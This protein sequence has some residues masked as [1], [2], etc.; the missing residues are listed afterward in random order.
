MLHY[1]NI[2]SMKRFKKKTIALV[3]ASVIAMTSAF[4]AEG[5]KNT[6]KAL[7]FS[8]MGSS[9]NVKIYTQE[10]FNG[11][12]SINRKMGGEYELILP[13]TESDLTQIPTHSADILSIDIS[14]I[15]Y[16]ETENGYTKIIIKTRPN[17]HLSA[18]TSLYK[19]ESPLGFQLIPNE[20]ED[21]TSDVSAEEEY[22]EDPL[23]ENYDESTE[24]NATSELLKVDNEKTSEQTNLSATGNGYVDE[25]VPP[26]EESPFNKIAAIFGVI[27]VISIVV[28]LFMRAKAQMQELVGDQQ[29]FDVSDEEPQTKTKKINKTVKKLDRTYSKKASMPI[30]QERSS[31]PVTPISADSN[32]N[33]NIEDLDALFNEAKQSQNANST[34]DTEE[35]IA[36]EEF[37]SAYS[38]E[39]EELAQANEQFVEVTPSDEKVVIEELEEA[40]FDE[41]LFEKCI[42]CVNLKF[43]QGDIDKI[44]KLLNSEINDDTLKNIKN[45][46]VSNPI[47]K[48]RSKTEVLEDIVT[49]YAIKQN[50]IFTHEDII[51]LNKLISVEIDNDFITDLKTDPIRQKEIL[52]EFKEHSNIHKVSEVLKLDV[53]KESLPNLS[54]AIEKQGN[55][56]IESNYKPE[57]VYFSKGYDVQTLEM[58]ESMPDLSVEIN[59]RDAYKTRPSDIFQVAESGYNVDTLKTS[60]LPDLQDALLNPE[61]YADPEEEP[62]IVTE[63][64]LLKKIDNVVFKPFDDGSRNFEVINNLE[65]FIEEEIIEERLSISDIQKELRDLGHLEIINEDFFEVSKDSFITE[66]LE[67]IDELSQWINNPNE[68]SIDIGELDTISEQEK[69]EEELQEEALPKLKK[70]ESV[71]NKNRINENAEN[72]LKLIQESEQ[73]TKTT[74]ALDITQKEDKIQET[75]ESVISPETSIQNIDNVHPKDCYLDGEK[76][77]IVTVSKIEKEVGCYLTKK[78]EN[79]V[80]IGY[81][82]G[83][84]VKLREYETLK[85]EK[86][87]ARVSETLS[88]GTKRCI[89]RL[90]VHKFILNA[91]D[92]KMEFVMDLC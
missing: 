5:Y 16:T 53:G 75:S 13:E 21:S 10:N 23:E 1:D 42:N 37:L 55:K 48:E 83:H 88:D 34:E 25:E 33:L 70:R 20:P 4:G 81:N 31:Q 36:L 18:S 19:E 6:L 41:E 32:S 35:N 92:Q 72:L 90:G 57:V 40:L 22:Y 77:D 85:N 44:N 54:E 8:G 78:N 67:E 24:D 69:E 65:D 79:Y 60:G 39:E 30:Y 14:T 80:V 11:D 49:T 82:K 28:F 51:A 64:D 2:Y 63:E 26:Q 73:N 74:E 59:K 46:A 29:N 27:I 62:V 66:S 3:F 84:L 87:Q 17:V 43:S 61:K 45:Y 86:I 71:R 56:R 12:I 47:K 76:Y 15:P 91:K 9:S 7:S 89:V 50:I 68:E 58:K 52:K 38:F